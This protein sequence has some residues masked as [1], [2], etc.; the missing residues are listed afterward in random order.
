VPIPTGSFLHE[1]DYVG[2]KHGARRWRSKDGERLYTWDDLHNHVEVYNKRG[3]HLGVLDAVS[4]V[5]IG[6]AVRGRTI[7]V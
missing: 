6:D 5:R 1:Q 7:D 4:G 3:D 2:Y